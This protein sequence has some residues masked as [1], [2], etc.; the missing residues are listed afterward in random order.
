MVRCL[1]CASNFNAEYCNQTYHTTLVLRDTA[2]KQSFKVFFSN[3]RVHELYLMIEVGLQDDKD[4][5]KRLLQIKEPF[6]TFDAI[7]NSTLSIKL[8]VHAD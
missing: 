7:K 3:D 8:G 4:F 1:L 6:I 5:V 2:T